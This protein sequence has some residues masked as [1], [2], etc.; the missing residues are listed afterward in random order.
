MT[1]ISA[2]VKGMRKFVELICYLKFLFLLSGIN[3]HNF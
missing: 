1:K 3:M 2:S